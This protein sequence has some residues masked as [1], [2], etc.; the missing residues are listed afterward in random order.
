MAKETYGDGSIFQRRGIWYVQFSVRGKVRQ[1]SARTTN[2]AKARRFL[3]QQLAA[4]LDGRAPTDRSVRLA[5]LWHQLESDYRRNGRRSL[6]R[7][8]QAWAHIEQAFGNPRAAD[9]DARDMTDYERTRSAAGAKP[10]TVR[11]ELATL[12]R[13]FRIG[14]R[15]GLVAAVPCMPSIVP[16]NARKVFFTRAEFDAIH[17]NLPEPVADTALFAFYTGWRRQ[18]I[19]GLR[20]RD[21]D[22]A[23]GIARAERTKNGDSR[24][25]PFAATPELAAM[26]ARRHAL[27]ALLATDGRPVPFVFHRLGR[28]IRDFRAAWDAALAKAGF[29]DRRIFHD[30]RRTATRNLVRAGV[31]RDVART[32]T[33]HRTDSIFTRYNITDA[34]DLE[35]AAANLA[36]YQERLATETAY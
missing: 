31:S 5:D 13:A 1:L 32:L 7:A 11:Y 29:T 24:D 3:R 18:E 23:A 20:W 28:P 33:G 8:R 4:A 35:Q 22:F 12:R 26:L 36:R 14:A 15:T 2:E 9:L 25:F 34:T 19:L 30:L 16:D 21:V 6:R 17:R 10:A 27:A